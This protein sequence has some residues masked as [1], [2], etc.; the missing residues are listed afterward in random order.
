MLGS[1]GSQSENH[2][3]RIHEPCMHESQYSTE[4]FP[5]HLM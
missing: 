5:L 1:G 2:V 3:W 4:Q